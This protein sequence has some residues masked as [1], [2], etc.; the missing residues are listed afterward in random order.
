LARK[1]DDGGP[2]TIYR[3]CGRRR[4][5]SVS[6]TTERKIAEQFAASYDGF[7]VP[8]PVVA[9]AQVDRENVFAYDHGQDEYEVI[10]DPKALRSLAVQGC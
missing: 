6:W 10:V 2:L 4:I 9:T 7:K 5:R 1:D 3:G 8:D